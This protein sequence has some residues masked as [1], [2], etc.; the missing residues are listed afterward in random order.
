MAAGGRDSPEADNRL[1][2]P[3]PHVEAKARSGLAICLSNL[4]EERTRS[5]ELMRQA[6]ALLRRVVRTSPGAQVPARMLAGELNTL[7]AMLVTR[8]HFADGMA[9]AEAALREVRLWGA[10]PPG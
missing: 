2:V 5:L 7:G 1:L 3:A 9:E 10:R 8:P 6:V 4:H